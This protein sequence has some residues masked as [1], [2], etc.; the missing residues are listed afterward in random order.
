[1]MLLYIHIMATHTFGFCG[2]YKTSQ[3]KCHPAVNALY[4]TW[5]FSRWQLSLFPNLHADTLEWAVSKPLRQDCS[6]LH[7]FSSHSCTEGWRA[8]VRPQSQSAAF[9]QVVIARAAAF[10]VT[11]DGRKRNDLTVIFMAELKDNFLSPLGLGEDTGCCW[12][13]LRLLWSNKGRGGWTL[14]FSKVFPPQGVIVLA[15]WS[16]LHIIYAIKPYLISKSN[17]CPLFKAN[18]TV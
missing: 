14:T 11:D 4:Y 17:H 18:K 13:S 9:A 3:W 12:M 10:S 7:G 6:V 2:S 15:F 8:K 1:M 16:V 5:H